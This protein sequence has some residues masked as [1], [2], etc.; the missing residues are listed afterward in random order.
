MSG[1]AQDDLH[2]AGSVGR[3]ERVVQKPFHPETLARALAEALRNRA[4]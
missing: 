1:Y 4:T 2:R 3:G